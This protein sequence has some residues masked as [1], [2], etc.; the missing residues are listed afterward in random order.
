[1]TANIPSQRILIA[2]TQEML[3]LYQQIHVKT[4][5]NHR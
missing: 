4:L 3:D 2:R 1:M 5:E